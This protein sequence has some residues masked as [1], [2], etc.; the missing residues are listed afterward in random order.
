[1]WMSHRGSG[2]VA[3]GIQGCLAPHPALRGIPEGKRGLSMAEHTHRR[4]NHVTAPP[5]T[6]PPVTGA[7]AGAQP[8]LP[9][10]WRGRG[11]RAPAVLGRGALPSLL[12][13]L[14]Q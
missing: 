6:S 9:R 13:S 1:M 7:A 2:D 14:L 3:G 4:K 8:G 11:A 5:N 10:P 12:N